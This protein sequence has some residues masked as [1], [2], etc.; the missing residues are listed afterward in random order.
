MRWTLDASGRT[1]QGMKLYFSPLACSAAT[2][3]AFYEAR[4][5][6]DY[7]EV[8]PKTKESAEG[9]FRAI[10]S[11]GLVPALRTD[12]GDLLTENAAIL[13]Y[14]AGQFPRADL[15]PRNDRERGRIQQ[16]LCFIGTE[17]HKGLYVPLL[18][19][20]APEGAKT[21]AIAKGEPRL[22]YLAREL[23]GR[24]FLLD[25]F[26]VA[27][28]YLATILNWSQVTPV[29]LKKWPVLADYLQRMRT[30]PSVARALS[31]ELELY[32]LE[33]ARHA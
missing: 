24:E 1:F 2:R 15:G 17:L 11:L 33:L 18:D 31:E 4:A 29:E 7:V 20:K 9:D 8:D 16:W 6:V 28:A 23:E 13:Q 32:K 30:R 19:A 25:H 22:N 21:Y 26:T 14:V 27:D 12:D 5:E 3:I 10:Y